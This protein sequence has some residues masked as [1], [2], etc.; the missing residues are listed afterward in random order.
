MSLAATSKRRPHADPLSIALRSEPEIDAA[1]D[2]RDWTRP[3]MAAAVSLLAHALLLGV[4]AS[5]TSAND[6]RT[7]RNLFQSRRISRLR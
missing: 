7:T 1:N 6:P 2:H 3:T 5:S 4:L